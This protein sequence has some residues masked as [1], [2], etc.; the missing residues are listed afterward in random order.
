LRSAGSISMAIERFYRDSQASELRIV[1]R[2]LL[3]EILGAVRPSW[4]RAEEEVMNR[5]RVAVLL[6]EALP[7]EGPLETS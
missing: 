2:E 5:A 1:P 7:D 3:A 6:A 4:M